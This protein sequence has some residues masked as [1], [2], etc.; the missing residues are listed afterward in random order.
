[1]MMLH[2]SPPKRSPGSRRTIYV[3]LRPAEGILESGAQSERW[4]ELR[5][6]WMGLILK[7]ADPTDWPADWRQDYPDDLGSL[8]EETDDIIA[9]WEPPIPAVYSVESIE[10]PD[11]PVPADMQETQ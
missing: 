4:V 5:K 2:G 6:R 11:Y 1:M 3:E 7:E 9:C 10:T 8:R